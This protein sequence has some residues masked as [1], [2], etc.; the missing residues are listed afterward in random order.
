MV[1]A[2]AINTIGCPSGGTC[3]VPGTTAHAIAQRA[4][5]DP[6]KSGP[7]IRAAAAEHG[8]DVESPR[9]CEVAP[10]TA[11][12]RPELERRPGGRTHRL[13]DGKFAI[14]CAPERDQRIARKSQ[15]R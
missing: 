6:A 1:C 12:H 14:L 10:A 4:S 11:P 15:L 9:D 8:R 3:T 5:L 2:S 7:Q 13:P